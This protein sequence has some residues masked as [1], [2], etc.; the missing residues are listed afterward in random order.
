MYEL[1]DSSYYPTGAPKIAS[2]RLF[3][4][5]HSGTADHNKNVITKSMSDAS[6]VV[7]VAF[8]TVALGMGVNFADLNRI[9]HYG[10]PR[11]L[12]NYLQECGR[13]G[14]SGDQAYSTIY[15]CPRDAPMYKD[16]SDQYKQEITLVRQYLENTETCRRVQLLKYF[17]GEESKDP[18]VPTHVG[19]CCD[20]C[21]GHGIQ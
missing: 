19:I 21:K 10:A 12:D 16:L 6:G 11:S 18:T 9:I 2:N 15:W 4:M 7:R 13:A 3:G 14:R 20:V 1:G 17:I 5:Y 8:A